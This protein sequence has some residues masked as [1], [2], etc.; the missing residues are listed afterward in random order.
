MDWSVS[1]WV[2]FSRQI[3]AIFESERSLLLKLVAG[4]FVGFC[5]GASLARGWAAN[6][7]KKTPVLVYFAIVAGAIVLAV[8][9]VFVLHLKDAVRRRMA[10]AQ[11]VHRVLRLLLASGW[12]SLLLWVVA[13][14]HLTHLQVVV[15]RH[16]NPKQLIG[17]EASLSAILCIRHLPWPC[18]HS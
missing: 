4:A 10:I 8:G 17:L 5:V 6:H 11:P 12:L 14:H 18:S 13:L 3:N 2:P 9:L 16:L 15:V 1:V 7:L